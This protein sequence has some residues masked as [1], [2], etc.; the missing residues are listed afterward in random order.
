MQINKI[1]Q[2]FVQ[3]HADNQLPFHVLNQLSIDQNI[4]GII[5]GTGEVLIP[6]NIIRPW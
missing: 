2:T 6:V 5:D 3:S 4:G 1:G